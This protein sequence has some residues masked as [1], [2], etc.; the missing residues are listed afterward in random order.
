MRFK[1]EQKAERKKVPCIGLSVLFLY[2]LWLGSMSC[3]SRP[4]AKRWQ[5]RF[6]KSNRFVCLFCSLSVV[7]DPA[8]PLQL[9]QAY[10]D[11]VAEWRALHEQVQAGQLDHMSKIEY[12]RVCDRERAGLDAA[13]RA[14]RDYQEAVAAYNRD[15]AGWVAAVAQAAADFEAAERAR[16]AFLT[17]QALG[18]CDMAEGCMQERLRGLGTVRLVYADTS[19]DADVLA[20]CAA[21]GTGAARP[22]PLVA[23]ARDEV[24]ALAAREQAAAAAAGRSGGR[25]A[26][27]SKK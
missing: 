13:N 11:R 9:Y 22:Q 26:T 19:A 18:Y 24:L 10:V 16:I 25:R 12:T 23:A 3:L 4:G 8:S 21:H 5:R 20:F 7:T 1:D 27:A 15:Q 14:D 17:A 6:P 2:S